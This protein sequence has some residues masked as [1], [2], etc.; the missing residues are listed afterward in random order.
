MPAGSNLVASNAN[1][2]SLTGKPSGPDPKITS[3]DG[4]DISSE[5]LVG[6]VVGGAAFIAIFML[7]LAIWFWRRKK[8]RNEVIRL[9]TDNSGRH[10][11]QIDLSSHPN[12]SALDISPGT[13]ERNNFFEHYKGLNGGKGYAARVQVTT[14]HIV[15]SHIDLFG[16]AKLAAAR[17]AV[18]EK[19]ELGGSDD[20][21]H[22][23]KKKG[24]SMSS[25]GSSGLNSRVSSKESSRLSS[26]RGAR[27]Q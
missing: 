18:K 3:Y 6:I 26:K 23:I 19:S 11:Q 10:W 9:Q 13:Q 7:G 27:K 25:R 12:I 15:D 4:S 20:P 5:I 22:Q 2:E 17:E 21:G 14:D 16:A 24:S 8:I 1:I